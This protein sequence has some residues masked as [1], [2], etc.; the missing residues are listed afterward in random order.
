MVTGVVV[1]GA[2]IAAVGVRVG[3]VVVQEVEF[4]VEVKACAS[5]TIGQKADCIARCAGW[6]R[7]TGSGDVT[8]LTPMPA[9]V[10]GT[11]E[12]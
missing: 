4:R 11:L 10:E 5:G 2:V 6:S 8:V 12:G 9:I 1:D 7:N 3:V